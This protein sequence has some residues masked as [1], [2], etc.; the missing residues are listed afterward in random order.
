MYFMETE[1]I[2]QLS[3]GFILSND[4]IKPSLILLPE[5]QSYQLL[6]VGLLFIGLILVNRYFSK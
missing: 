6:I 2:M 5:P 1:F 4:A 3:P